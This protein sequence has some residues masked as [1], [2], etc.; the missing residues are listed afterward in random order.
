MGDRRESKGL[1]PVEGKARWSEAGGRHTRTR[2]RGADFDSQAVRALQLFRRVGRTLTPRSHF[3]EFVCHLASIAVSNMS[4]RLPNGKRK[5]QSCA[6]CLP[7]RATLRNR[8]RAI[9]KRTPLRTSGVKNTGPFGHPQYSR[10]LVKNPDRVIAAPFAECE[11]CHAHLKGLDPDA[12]IRRQI[13]ELPR[14]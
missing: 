12:V 2:D 7:I 10:P 4:G 9:R 14:L 13:T 8:H 6:S 1:R 11:H 5:L 3:F